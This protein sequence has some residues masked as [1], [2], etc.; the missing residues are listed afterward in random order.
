M[1][2]TGTALL[3]G[4]LASAGTQVAR[5]VMGS[6]AAKGAAEIQTAEADR[7]FARTEAA[8]REAQDYLE[9]R[10]QESQSAYAPYAAAGGN[11]L[12][13]LTRGMGL[14][15]GMGQPTQAT[16]AQPTVAMHAQPRNALAALPRSSSNLGPLNNAT[17]QAMTGLEGQMANRQERMVL[18]ADPTG[19]RRR[20]VPERKVAQFRARGAQV[21]QE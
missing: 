20:M 9:A 2:G 16:P 11:A 4:T 18:M 10:R 3:I 7:Q 6:K 14:P 13:A 21:V 17:N 5:G 19:T 15:T 1:V 8:T 12:A